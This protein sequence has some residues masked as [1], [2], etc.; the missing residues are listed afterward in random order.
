MVSSDRVGARL[1][2]CSVLRPF[3]QAGWTVGDV[4]IALDVRPGEGRWPH[5]A[6]HGVE[7]VGAWLAYRL[8]PWTSDGEPRRSP[9]QRLAQQHAENQARRRAEAERA[10]R[11]KPASREVVREALAQIRRALRR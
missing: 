7:N 8:H 9:S 6:G 10:A 1:H 11:T 4:V 3:F 5:D 2:E